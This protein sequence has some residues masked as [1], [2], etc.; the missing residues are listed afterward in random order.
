MLTARPYPIENDVKY[1]PKELKTNINVT[2]TSPPK[3]LFILLGGVLAFL[4]IG[5]VV[6]GF[7][8]DFVVPRLPSSVEQTLSRP[9]ERNFADAK[10][11]KKSEQLEKVLQKLV[12]VMPEKRGTYKVYLVEHKQVNAMAL[13][14]GNIVV[15]SGL[16]DE[17]GSEQELAFVLGHELGHFANRD[18]LKGLGRGLLLYSLLSLLVGPDSSLAEIMG[19]TLVGIQMK[20]SQRQEIAAD[21]YALDLLD[22]QYEQVSGAI[23][24]MEKLS[25][26]EKKGHFAY[27]FST[28]PHPETRITNIKNEIRKR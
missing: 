16:M 5:Y 23:E 15:F 28:H 17:V 4:I 25:I 27:Y 10:E 2:K 18:H 8:V 26:K 7:A 14:G 21:T 12:D 1:V 24:F 13:P 3:E 11:N 22:R 19:G 6:L 9:F 20:Y